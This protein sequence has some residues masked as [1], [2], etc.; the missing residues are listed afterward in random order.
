MTSLRIPIVLS[1]PLNSILKPISYRS[2]FKPNA[3]KIEMMFCLH[4]CILMGKRLAVF[5]N[6]FLILQSFSLVKN[7]KID[8]FKKKVNFVVVFFLKL[9][10]IWLQNGLSDLK[11]HQTIEILLM[12]DFY[13]F[14]KC[15]IFSKFSRFFKF[16]SISW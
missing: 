3:N 13:A 2:L 15:C 12:V 11:K 14:L 16:I 9:A 10:F 5:L 1:A 8:F 4:M 7:A 6:S